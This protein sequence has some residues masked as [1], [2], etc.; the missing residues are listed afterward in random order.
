[1]YINTYRAVY[2]AQ[3]IKIGVCPIRGS[4]GCQG[5]TIQGAKVGPGKRGHDRTT[6]ATSNG[7]EAHRPPQRRWQ[8]RKLTVCGQMTTIN[9]AVVAHEVAVMIQHNRVLFKKP[10]PLTKP[11]QGEITFLQTRMPGA[12]QGP[13]SNCSRSPWGYFYSGPTISS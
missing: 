5:E 6:P 2:L 8:L 4:A 7:R 11:T 10:L 12:V 3:L 13:R 1:M 9:D